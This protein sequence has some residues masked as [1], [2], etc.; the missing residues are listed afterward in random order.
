MKTCMKC[1]ETY[2]E[3]IDYCFNDG[4]VLVL[5]P[6]AM[7]APLP[8]NVASNTSV[9]RGPTSLVDDDPADAPMPRRVLMPSAVE[10]EM[11]DIQADEIFEAPAPDPEGFDA[12]VRG[13]PTAADAPPLP[14]AA[15]PGGGFDP[16]A[17]ALAPPD[18]P[19]PDSDEVAPPVVVPAATVAPVVPAP[20]VASV[21]EPPTAQQE[22][23]PAEAPG[24]PVFEGLDEDFEDDEEVRKSGG[25]LWLLFAAAGVVLVGGI[26]LVLFGGEK[27]E[28]KP[29]VALIKPV[30]A[31]AVEPAPEAIEPLEEAAALE[32]VPVDEP[33]VVPEPELV[34]EPEPEPAPRAA[35]VVAPPTP[36]PRAT[37]PAPREPTPAPRAHVPEPQ[38]EPEPEPIAPP[39]V[40]AVAVVHTPEPEPEPEPEVAPEVAPAAPG[41]NPWGV[42]E[43]PSSADASFTSDPP[44][45]EVWIDG[46]MVGTTPL[47]RT[48]P[49]AAYRVEFKLEGYESASKTVDVQSASP[50]FPQTLTRVPRSGV[51]MVFF[52]GRDGQTLLMDG[53]PVGA[54]PARVTISEGRHTFVIQGGDGDLTLKRKVE[55]KESGITMLKLHE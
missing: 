35:E 43:T 49:F 8:R 50:S 9:A 22:P 5:L 21:G 25:M 1:G 38:P 48:L 19:D 15:S 17:E 29:E 16:H 30:P 28:P 47:T 11:V 54:L 2:S 51:A 27:P 39:I 45:A 41:A 42:V 20:V 55:L 14:G 34:P 32:E 24:G 26:G 53:A 44:G 46:A 12:P 36:A 52:E 4:E 10:P 7:D 40:P 6:S 3:R 13:A 18:D 33:E 23:A 31:V 37:T